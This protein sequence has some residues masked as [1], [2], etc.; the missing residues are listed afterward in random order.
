MFDEDGSPCMPFGKYSGEPLVEIPRGY[1]C[2][3]LKWDRTSDDLAAA[4]KRALS[5]RGLAFGKHKDT[6]LEDVPT[7][8]LEWLLANV[9]LSPPLP[10]LIEAELAGRKG[11]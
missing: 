3:A 5:R 9:E 10:E 7:G 2:E 1:L 8:Y 4:I 6:P 11:W